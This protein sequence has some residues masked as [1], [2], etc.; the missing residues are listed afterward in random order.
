MKSSCLGIFLGVPID[1]KLAPLIDSGLMR[2][3]GSY[4]DKV[5]I[6]GLSF[7]GKQLDEPLTIEQLEQCQAHVL[8]LLKRIMPGVSPPKP[9]CFSL[10]Y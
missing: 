4:L 5:E 7:L 6:E 8:S 10:T 1:A 3:F 2:L 9:H